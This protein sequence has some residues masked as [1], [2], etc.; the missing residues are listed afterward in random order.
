MPWKR[1]S[2]TE[3]VHIV[4]TGYQKKKMPNKYY[5][6]GSNNVSIAKDHEECG[7]SVSS[8]S[9]YALVQFHQ[10]CPVE[11]TS[12]SIATFYQQYF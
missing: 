10:I 3:I 6:S 7:S 12:H 11:F 1:C 8:Y 5:V 4:V 2:R 9:L